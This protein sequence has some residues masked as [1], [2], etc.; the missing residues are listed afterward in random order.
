TLSITMSVKSDGKRKWAAVRGHLGSSQ[1][2]DTQLEANLESADPELCICMLQV[3]SVVN[4]SGL[5]R[6]LEGSEESWMVQFLELSGLDLLLEALDRLSGR[7][8]SRIT[9][10]LL[11]LTCVSCV[12]AIMNSSAGIHFIMENEGYIRKLSQALD[13]SNTMV[14]KQVFE[15]LAALSMFSSDGYRQA[16]DALDHYKASGVKTQL[17]RFGVIMNEL[18]ATDNVPYMVTLLSV[19]NAIIFGTDDLRQRDKM[20]KEF[21]GLQLLDILP[22]LRDEEDEDLIIQ[23]EV[24]E[25]AMYEDEEELLRVYGGI[26]MSSHQ[27]VFITLFNK[28]SSSPSSLQLLSILQALLLLGP[29]RADIWQALEALTNRAILLDQDYHMD[30]CEMIMQRLVF[31]KRKKA[32]VDAV[33]GLPP[34]KIDKAVQTDMVDDDQERLTKCSTI[35]QVSSPPPHPPPSLSPNMMEQGP[36]QCPPPPPPPLQHIGGGV[37]PPPPPLPGMGV[38]PGCPPPPPPPPPPPGTGGGGPPPPPPLPGLLPPPPPPPP[39]GMGGIVVAQSSQS[40]GCAPAAAS[41][42]GHGH[43]IWTSAQKDAP[44]EPN[45]SSI[46]QLFCLPV[47]EHKDQGAAAPVKNEPKEISFIDAKKNLNLNIF[48]KQFKCSRDEFVALIQSGDRSKFDVEVLKQLIKLLPEKHEI[49]NLKSFL[50]EKEKLANVDRFYISL[51]AVPCYQ[52]RID[53]MLLCE[54]TTSVLDMLK[55]KAEGSQTG[56]A[57]GFKISSLLKLTETKANKS[58]ITLLHHILEEAELNHPELLNLPDDIEICEKAAGVNLDSIQ[59][60]ASALLKRLKEVAKKVSNSLDDVK[61]Q[62]TKAIEENLEACLDLEERFAEIVRKKGDLALY[63]CEDANQLSLE[64]LF[65]TIKTFRGLF[66]KALKENKTRKEQ[67]VKAE[68]RKKQLEEEESKRQKGENGK[69]I[70]KGPPPQDDGCII[71]HLLADIRKGF[72]LRKMRPRCETDSPLSSEM[73]RDTGQ[74][75]S[76]VKPVKEEVVASVSEASS[77]LN[78]TQ[79]QAEERVPRG[80]VNGCP[81]KPQEKHPKETAW[82]Q[83]NSLTLEI[84]GTDVLNNTPSPS[85]FTDLVE[86]NQNENNGLVTEDLMPEC[87]QNN[88]ES[89]LN[90]AC[91]LAVTDMD[92]IIESKLIGKTIGQDDVEGESSSMMVKTVGPDETGDDMTVKMVAQDEGVTNGHRDANGNTEAN[93]NKR[94]VSAAQSVLA[95]DVH[96]GVESKD[97]LSSV[98]ETLPSFES[99]P[100][101]PEDKIQQTLFRRNKKK[102]NEGNVFINSNKDHV[103]NCGLL[104]CMKGRFFPFFLGGFIAFYIIHFI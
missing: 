3:P 21:I 6:R 48:L 80:G 90:G 1:D 99:G 53:C 62:F 81:S 85:T 71:D 97:L 4:Y 12:R 29:D 61:E 25:E 77:T 92:M 54:E 45:Y 18:Q 9:D 89:H 60:E 63:L 8:R 15:L 50:G 64:E 46:E 13:T 104:K 24:F 58:R 34:K 31:S 10:A 66:L 42:A 16:L 72:H 82:S 68:K 38:P 36:R 23:C 79:S 93:G 47:T 22:K 70:R 78:P 94:L 33:D 91:T 84:L 52:L 67:A 86:I 37:P 43:S 96:D 76:S 30:S 32:G 19:I 27:E 56:N 5:K 55:P 83:T 57:E 88:G 98:S 87:P 49:E 14:K 40:L 20:R 41:K 95:Y 101:T 103:W 102:G 44:L 28:V 17:F 73:N 74:P 2:S 59:A 65:S 100:L 7:G 11:Q 26:D 75:G 35:S 69:I 39:P 51:L